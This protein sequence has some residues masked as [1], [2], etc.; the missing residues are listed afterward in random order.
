MRLVKL[1]LQDLPLAGGSTEELA[2]GLVA[3]GEAV[4]V[5]LLTEERLA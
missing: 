1:P 4:H 2:T 3:A 5:E